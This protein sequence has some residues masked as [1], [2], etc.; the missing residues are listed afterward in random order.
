MQ[1]DSHKEKMWDKLLDQVMNKHQNIGNLRHTSC[2]GMDGIPSL[3]IDVSLWCVV[4]SSMGVL[5]VMFFVLKTKEWD[6]VELHL[7]SSESIL[8]LTLSCSK[9]HTST[10]ACT[11]PLHEAF[12]SLCLLYCNF[13]LSPPHYLPPSCLP[14][15]L[16][17]ALFL[18]SHYTPKTMFLPRMQSMGYLWT[19]HHRPQLQK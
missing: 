12:N 18:L 8:L 2:S 13:R 10:K 1:I 14:F 4:L 6:L 17:F 5:H 11:S 15:F 19:Y 9:H 16:F 3:Y 7:N